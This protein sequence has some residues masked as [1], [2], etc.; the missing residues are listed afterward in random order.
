MRMDLEIFWGKI[1]DFFSSLK[2]DPD[3][4]KRTQIKKFISQ[5]QNFSSYS[6]FKFPCIS[7]TCVWT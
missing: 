5:T 2:Y 4:M 6:N 7:P 3:V 1:Y